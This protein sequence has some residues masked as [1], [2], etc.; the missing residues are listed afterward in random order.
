MGLYQTKPYPIEAI[1]WTG[2]N[3]QEVM[4]FLEPPCECKDHRR[5]F[6]GV[7]VIRGALYGYDWVRM[8]HL[9]IDTGI[10]VVKNG[11]VITYVSPEDFEKR[12][13]PRSIN[14]YDH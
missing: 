1:Q 13:E 14:G 12:Y 10:W 3:F 11:P 8:E 6:S 5:R 2:D 9:D 4:D 7:N